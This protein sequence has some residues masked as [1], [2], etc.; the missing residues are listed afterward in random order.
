VLVACRAGVALAVLVSMA[1]APIKDPMARA[2]ASYNAAQFDQA[3]E[4]ATEAL[5]LPRYVNTANIVIARARMER[6]RVAFAKGE[7]APSDLTTARDLLKQVDVSKLTP[8]DHIEYLTG[9]GE[10]LYLEDLASG[11]PLYSAAAEVFDR[12]LSRT[13]SEDAETREMLFEWWAGSLDRQAQLASDTERRQ[14]YA[15]VL[16]RAEKELADRDLSPSATYWVAASSRG[17]DDVERAW[18]AAV[19]G[20]IRAREMGPAG[21]R[22]RDDLDRL[23]TQGILPERAR[24]MSPADARSMENVLKARWDEFRTLWEKAPGSLLP[25]VRP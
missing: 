18:G 25:A 4:A 19:A 15:R 2:R 23:V 17:T 10:S 20:W 7:Q 22:L 12:A 6:F 14:L 3:I 13:S 11:Q 1:Q 9:V 16:T 8:R 21:L 24:L 5:Q